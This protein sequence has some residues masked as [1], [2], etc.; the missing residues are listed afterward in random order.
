MILNL[1]QLKSGQIGIIT[2]IKG[3]EGLVRRLDTMGLAIGRKVLKISAQVWQG[4][5]VIKVNN[6]SQV[7][8]GFGMA[9]KILVEVAECEK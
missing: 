5:Q 6:A 1:T 8:I 4:P 3:G 9:K 2:E 7:A